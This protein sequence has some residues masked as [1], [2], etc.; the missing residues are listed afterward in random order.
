MRGDRFLGV[1][2][3]IGDAAVAEAAR[4]AAEAGVSPGSRVVMVNPDGACRFT[5]LPFQEQ[6]SLLERLAFTTAPETL[7]L[8]GA[9]HSWSG[10]GQR[11]LDAVPDALRGKLRII[12]KQMSLEAYAALMDLA[13]VFITGDTGPLHLAAA[14][15]YSRSGRH[16]FRNRTAVLSLFG[17]TV[18]RMSG[19]DSHQPGYLTRQPG[20]AVLVLSGRQSL[21]QPLV[22]QQVLQDV[23]DGPVLRAGGHRPVW[24]IWSSRISRSW[25]GD[26]P[27]IRDRSHTR[28][29]PR[30]ARR[31]QREGAAP[32]SSWRLVWVSS[33]PFRSAAR[34]SRWRSAPC[35]GTCAPPPPSSSGS[36]SSDVMYGAVALFGIA[37]LL[38]TPW[39]LASLSAAGAVILWVLAFLTFRASRRPQELGAANSPLAS[40]RWAYLTGFSLAVSNPQ[41]M[42]SWLLAVALAKHVGLASPFPVSAKVLFIGGGAAG[43]GGYLTVLGAVVYRLKHFVPL[44]AIGRV[45]VWLAFTLL[46]LSALF[47]IGAVRFFLVAA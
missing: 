14:R 9:G 20:C 40:G 11:L 30:S 34:R 7:I 25:A 8:L 38:D 44:T 47:V 42:V 24:P 39:V 43:L 22:P 28:A 15:R 32:R 23:P 3:T 37:P 31:P 5:L 21:P 10:V 45:Y 26:Q 16:Q 33:P 41:M 27:A 29:P 46:A 6:A 17:A 13:D 4:Y 18:P 19:Y 36:V 1:R 12:P 2:T 35:T